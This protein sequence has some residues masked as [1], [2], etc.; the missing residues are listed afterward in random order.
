[1]GEHV[2]PSEVKAQNGASS[3]PLIFCCTS[4][5]QP[6]SRGRDGRL[7]LDEERNTN[8]TARGVGVDTGRGREPRP[9]CAGPT[10]GAPLLA[11]DRTALDEAGSDLCPWELTVVTL[12][13]SDEEETTLF[14]SLRRTVATVGPHWTEW[15]G[16]C[17][18]S[19][20][21]AL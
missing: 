10:P 5:G 13:D 2:K 15:S 11:A 14:R 6:S 3:F 12:D 16:Y 8:H 17:L 4:G 20:D 1:M 19:Q 9:R 7:C 21:S 18:F